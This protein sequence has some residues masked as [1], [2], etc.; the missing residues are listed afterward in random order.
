MLPARLAT[1]KTVE[2]LLEGA[3]FN[4]LSEKLGPILDE[5]K[6]AIEPFDET[7]ESSASQKA[8][9]AA[10][11]KTRAFARSQFERIR[12]QA[13]TPLFALLQSMTSA[14]L[15]NKVKR[16][17]VQESVGASVA[18]AK[19]IANTAIAGMQADLQM[20]AAKRIEARGPV[21]F[22]Y[23]GPM[24]KKTRPFCEEMLGMAVRQ[25]DIGKLNNGQGL[26]VARFGG[27]Y[28]CR[29]QWTAVSA[30]YIDATETDVADNA[31][32]NRANRAARRSS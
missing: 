16:A 27:G 8:S 1:D 4:E 12:Q 2:S 29:H 23:T 17:F 9:N 24:D 19:T 25:K 14:P 30:N 26:S 22:L 28:N 5:A 20:D 6:K 18:Q 15:T 32:I 13:K 31:Q 11:A 7:G 10:L 21:F 3:R